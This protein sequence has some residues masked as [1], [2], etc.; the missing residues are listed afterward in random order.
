[1]PNLYLPIF[2]EIILTLK[3]AILYYT[4]LFSADIHRDIHRNNVQTV[5]NGQ[6]VPNGNGNAHRI[7]QPPAQ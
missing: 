7:A 5:S 4:I 3:Y 2:P 1:M 6:L